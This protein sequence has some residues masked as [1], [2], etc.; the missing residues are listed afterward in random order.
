MPKLYL[1]STQQ[2]KLYLKSTQQK[3]GYLKNTLVYSADGNVFP[4]LDWTGG[5]AYTGIVSADSLKVILPSGSGKTNSV[6]RTSAKIDLTNYSKLIFDVSQYNND[7]SGAHLSV[8]IDDDTTTHTRDSFYKYIPVTGTGTFTVDVKSIT[9]SFYIAI[10]VW[11]S[12]QNNKGFTVS[13]I[14]AE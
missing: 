12:G 5:G 9:G 4:D 8:G 10:A 1:K 6:C 13:K 2:K 3:K 7:S 14:T 11:H